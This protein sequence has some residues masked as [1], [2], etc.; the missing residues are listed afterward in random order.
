MLDTHFLLT[1]AG[2]GRLKLS[3]LPAGAGP[4]RLKLTFRSSV[5]VSNTQNSL[6]VG[7]YKYGTST[8]HFLSTGTDARRS[9]LT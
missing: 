7:R 5:Q 9:E 6:L 1:G 3:F 2:P 8:T 4:E